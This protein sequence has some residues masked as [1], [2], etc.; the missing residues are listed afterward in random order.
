MKSEEHMK[1]G[2]YHSWMEEDGTLKLYRHSF[3]DSSGFSCTLSPEEA[4]GLLELL[5]RH[6]EDI[7]VALYTHEAQRATKSY[8]G[9]H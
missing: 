9:G 1:I 7:N 2:R 5:S 6:R 4:K 3:G 8:A